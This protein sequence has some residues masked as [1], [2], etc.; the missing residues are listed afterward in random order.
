MSY[1]LNHARRMADAITSKLNHWDDDVTLVFKSKTYNVKGLYIKHTNDYNELGVPTGQ[2]NATLT[3]SV[4]ELE[5]NNV[6][7]INAGGVIQLDQ[8]SS[9]AKVTV[10]DTIQVREYEI[11]STKPDSTLGLIVC[12][13]QTLSR[14]N[15]PTIIE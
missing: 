10:S 14:S 8:K 1:L 12:K 4:A 9:Q 2:Q 3:L 13:L 7:Y 15:K 11:V 5:R 6:P